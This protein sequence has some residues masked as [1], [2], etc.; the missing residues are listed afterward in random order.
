MSAAV[1]ATTAPAIP[2]A[3]AA[4]AA[5]EKVAWPIVKDDYELKDVIGMSELGFFTINGHRHVGLIVYRYIPVPG[6]NL[7][8]G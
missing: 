5:A 6:I 2:G 4:A 3:A 7:L 1:A 8:K